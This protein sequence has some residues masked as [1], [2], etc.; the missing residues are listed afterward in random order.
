MPPVTCPEPLARLSS[1]LHQ[2]VKSTH[3]GADWLPV[4]AFNDTCYLSRALGC[5]VYLLANLPGAVVWGADRCLGGFGRLPLVHQRV[6]I[7]EIHP[8]TKLGTPG[9]RR[10]RSRRGMGPP[11]SG[12]VRTGLPGCS[13]RGRGCRDHFARVPLRLDVPRLR[14]SLPSS[15]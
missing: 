15:Y 2:R 5:L 4:L 3:R 9:S 14:H 7:L 11:V 8:L 12:R 1:P 10:T 13:C 6:F